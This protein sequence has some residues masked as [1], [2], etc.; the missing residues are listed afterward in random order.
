V[1]LIGGYSSRVF[2]S[3]RKADY[4]IRRKKKGRKKKAGLKEAG[5]KEK[6]G[7]E[8]PPSRD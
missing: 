6:G 8:A 3:R 7:A 1:I 5:L 2:V 4:I